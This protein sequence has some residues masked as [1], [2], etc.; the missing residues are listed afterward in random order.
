MTRFLPTIT[1]THT[2]TQLAPVYN[3]YAMSEKES[4]IDRL[5]AGQQYDMATLGQSAGEIVCFDGQFCSAG[6]SANNCAGGIMTV[7]DSEWR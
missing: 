6:F 5:V 1:I 4:L 3:E 7:Y 2:H